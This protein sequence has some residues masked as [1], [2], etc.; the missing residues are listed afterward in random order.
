MDRGQRLDAG[1]GVRVIQVSEFGCRV[2]GREGAY[3]V[4]RSGWFSDRTTHYLASGKPALVQD[5]GFERTIPVGDGLIA[6]RTVRDAVAGARRIAV[7]YDHHAAAARQLADEHVA[8]EIVLARFVDEALSA[9][10]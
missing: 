9:P 6:F 2:L 4:T 5:T 7:D 3:V 10:L 8:A 1:P